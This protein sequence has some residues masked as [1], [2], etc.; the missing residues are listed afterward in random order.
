MAI[1]TMFEI[2]GDPDELMAKM[3][4]HTEPKARRAAAE[5]GGISNTVVKTDDGVMVVN[6]WESAE[7]MQRVAAE[8]G[9]IARDAGLSEQVGWRQ[10]EVLR[11]RTPG[12]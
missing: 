5:N 6:L 1:L 11:H 9:P 4:E 3:D 7:G 10:F 2:H 12:D 8:I